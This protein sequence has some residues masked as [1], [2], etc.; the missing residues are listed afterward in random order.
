MSRGADEGERRGHE[1]FAHQVIERGPDHALREIAGGAKQDEFLYGVF[2]ELSSSRAAPSN[3]MCGW[4]MVSSGTLRMA[5]VNRPLYSKPGTHAPFERGRSKCC[6][7]APEMSTPCQAPSV[8]A[9]SPA[10]EP[11]NSQNRPTASTQ[12]ASLPSRGARGDLGRRE[13]RHMLALD[14]AESQID[15]REAGAAQHPLSRHPAIFLAQPAQ[16]LDGLFTGGSK[17]GVPTFGGEHAERARR[18]R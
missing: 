7:M 1:L 14:F 6:S 18:W 5:G 8:S 3:S 9:R 2:H 17:A 11:S 10:N 16:Q 13:L 12:L 4:E 15:V